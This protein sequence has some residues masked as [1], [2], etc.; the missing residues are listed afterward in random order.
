MTSLGK[1]IGLTITA[2]LALA[3]APAGAWAQAPGGI[4]GVLNKAGETKTEGAKHAAAVD[5]VQADPSKTAKPAAKEAQG[6]AKGTAPAKGAPAKSGAAK[7][8]TPAKTSAPQEKGDPFVIPLRKSTT[9]TTIPQNL[10]PGQAGLMVS[11]VEVQGLVKA[12][13]GNRAIVRGPH[14]RTYFLKVNDKLYNGRVTKITDSA[15]FFE[16]TMV[17]PLGKV[18]RHEVEKAL[19]SGKK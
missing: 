15:V 7:S 11:Q 14:D 12:P 8:V 4:K 16:E 10:P 13:S 1:Q 3:I 6:T 5:A 9:D 2:V 17:D 18:Q 19:P